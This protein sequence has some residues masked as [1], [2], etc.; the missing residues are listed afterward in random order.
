[1]FN[2]L[3]PTPGEFYSAQVDADTG[4]LLN[5][6]VLADDASGYAQRAGPP[7]PTAWKEGA[8][9]RTVDGVWMNYAGNDPSLVPGSYRGTVQLLYSPSGMLASRQVRKDEIWWDTR[10]PRSFVAGDDLVVSGDVW[11]EHYKT[12]N[13]RVEEVHR[14][15]PHLNVTQEGVLIEDQSIPYTSR[16]PTEGRGTDPWRGYQALAREYGSMMAAAVD[17]APVPSR[18]SS[19]VGE[20]SLLGWAS[21]VA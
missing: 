3:T 15:N 12:G 8:I 16:I 11:D 18:R 20:G 7:D 17:H 13:Q 4:K 9:G 21:G 10:R 1:M 19:R 2:E 5:A 6:A 14:V